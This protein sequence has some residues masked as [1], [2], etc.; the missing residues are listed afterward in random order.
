MHWHWLV[1]SFNQQWLTVSVKSQMIMKLNHHKYAT[2]WITLLTN[3]TNFDIERAVIERRR[4]LHA[5]RFLIN[6]SD[7]SVRNSLS[8]SLQLQN[9]RERDSRTRF[10]LNYVF[11]CLCKKAWIHV[12]EMDRGVDWAKR[13]RRSVKRI[14]SIDK[15]NKH[16]HSFC[17]CIVYHSILDARLLIFGFKLNNHE[18]TPRSLYSLHRLLS[19]SQPNN[20][21]CDFLLFILLLF[22]FLS[23]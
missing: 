12:D 20:Y 6:S 10:E 4:N 14:N 11:I 16:F 17:L 13:H 7:D 8:T 23:S 22:L 5:G 18:T 15:M 21:A 2:A 3:V 1:H 19:A 9:E